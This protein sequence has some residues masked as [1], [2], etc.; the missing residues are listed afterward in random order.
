MTT[1]TTAGTGLR[2][3]AT[4]AE[5]AMTGEGM[6]LVI[7][8]LDLVIGLS[9][10]IVS[11]TAQEGI[12]TE[13]TTGL[14]VAEVLMKKE[15]ATITREGLHRPSAGGTTAIQVINRLKIRLP[16]TLPSP[17]RKFLM[18]TFAL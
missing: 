12:P 9:A 8:G 18:L 14:S 6:S 17:N 10:T 5:S 16:G 11:A 1:A 2:T 4:S 13:E 15:D 7:G 3:A